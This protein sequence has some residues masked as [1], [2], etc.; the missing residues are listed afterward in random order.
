MDPVDV[1]G[2]LCAHGGR[3]HL[4]GYPKNGSMTPDPT[5]PPQLASTAG[6]HVS[7]GFEW[8]EVGWEI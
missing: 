6:G 3:R 8:V 2:F 7:S 4:D 1:P 5:R